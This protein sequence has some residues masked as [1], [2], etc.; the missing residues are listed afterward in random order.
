MH[1]LAQIKLTGRVVDENSAPVGGALV[2]VRHASGPAPTAVQAETD[3]TG[4]FSV[5]L[6][7]PGDYLINVEHP[8]FYPL[9]DS[10]VQVQ[11]L[12]PEL[13]LTINTVREVFQSVNVQYVQH[14]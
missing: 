6:P 4:A 1:C 8:G 2:A 13:T 9:R 7:E 10:P 3:P 11:P 14:S 12:P 5:S